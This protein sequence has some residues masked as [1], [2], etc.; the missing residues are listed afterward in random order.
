MGRKPIEREPGSLIEGTRARWEVVRPL[1]RLK[2][3]RWW[4]RCLFCGEERV[5]SQHDIGM[6]RMPTCITL[7]APP[8]PR[9]DRTDVDEDDRMSRLTVDTRNARPRK[10]RS[11][12]IAQYRSD[13]VYRAT[14]YERGRLEFPV[15]EHG[16]PKTRGE[17][18]GVQ[19][20]CPFVSCRWHLYL[21]VLESGA[22]KLNFPD[23]EP[24]ELE[25]SCCLD[26][27]ERGPHR[28]EDVGAVMNLTRERVRQTEDAALAKVEA[29][30]AH[31]Q[32]AP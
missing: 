6:G 7:R 3:S 15:T 2:R 14:E 21:D 20:P 22:L 9:K 16:R 17:C 25:H 31:L 13:N 8:G 4:C 18:A 19:R 30:A 24:H 10:R 26:I 28:L 12:T 29:A 1:A 27:A 32:E 5:I 11:L 23:I